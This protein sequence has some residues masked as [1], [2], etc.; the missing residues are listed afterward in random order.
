MPPPII[1]VSLATELSMGNL[2]R[3]RSL[4]RTTRHPRKR[5]SHRLHKVHLTQKHGSWPPS[6]TV[7]AESSTKPRSAAPS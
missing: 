2:P 4:V 1:I 7:H 6:H 5:P 3:R